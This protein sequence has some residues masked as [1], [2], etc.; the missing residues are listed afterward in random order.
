MTID[1]PAKMLETRKKMGMNSEYQSGWILGFAIR[2]S[3]PRP[4]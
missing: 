4:D 2:Y 3:A 1:R